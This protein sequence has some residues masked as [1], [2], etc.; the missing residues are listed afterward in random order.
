VVVQV[1]DVEQKLPPKIPIVLKCPMSA[2]QGAVYNWVKHTSTIMLEPS[3]ARRLKSGKAWAP[4]NNKGM[5]MRK[6]GGTAFADAKMWPPC[7]LA[8]LS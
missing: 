8:V 3:N 7:N 5:E 2:Y 4:L 1:Q 6:V